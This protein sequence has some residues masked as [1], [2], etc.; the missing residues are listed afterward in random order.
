MSAKDQERMSGPVPDALFGALERQPADALLQLI[1]LYRQDTR[2]HKIDL[3]VGVYRNDAGETPVMRA[4]KAAE[5]RL[6]D[7]QATKAYLD[8]RRRQPRA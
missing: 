5:H 8:R 2:P 3:G 4:I 1:G 7:T 6:S